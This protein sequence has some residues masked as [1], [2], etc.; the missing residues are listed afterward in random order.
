V[1]QTDVAAATSVW[2]TPLRQELPRRLCAHIGETTISALEEVRQFFVIETEQAQQG[3]VE[4][5]DM[6]LVF[7]GFV[8]EIICRA[9]T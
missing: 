4:V 5:M 3:G 9:I 2:H 6:N 8:P 1:C 7:N